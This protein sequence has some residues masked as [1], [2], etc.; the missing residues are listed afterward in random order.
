MASMQNTFILNR[1]KK[2]ISVPSNLDWTMLSINLKLLSAAIRKSDKTEITNEVV[3]LLQHML[4]VAT[5]YDIDMSHA[6]KQ[7][8]KSSIEGLSFRL[9]ALLLDGRA[10]SV[11]DF[12]VASLFE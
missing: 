12:F 2:R 7:K 10:F 3:D 6:W 4:T 8:K 9:I 5:L 11:D 1:L